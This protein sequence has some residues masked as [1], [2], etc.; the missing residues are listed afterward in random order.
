VSRKRW[1]WI[2]AAVGVAA[3]FG[4]AAWSL[5]DDIAYARLAT[6]YAAKQTCSCIH[7]SSRSLESCVNDFPED[8]RSQLTVVPDGDRVRASVLLGVV[9]AEAVFEE[10]YGCR[11]LD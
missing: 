9:H 4:L 7:V 5:Q 3:V 11:I 8:A 1:I 2:G 6:G 10:G